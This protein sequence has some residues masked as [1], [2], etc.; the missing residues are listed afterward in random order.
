MKISTTLEFTV[1]SVIFRKKSISELK[2]I[3]KN[4][5]QEENTCILD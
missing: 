5:E 4:E 2:Y 3:W 1:P